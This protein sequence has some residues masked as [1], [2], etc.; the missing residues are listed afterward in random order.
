MMLGELRVLHLVPKANRRRLTSEQLG[1]RSLKAHPHSDTRFPT[2]PHLLI[3]SLLGPSVFKPPHQGVGGGGTGLSKKKSEQASGASTV[4]LL[5][6]GL[7]RCE[8]S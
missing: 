6:P 7:S 1:G 3:M 8:E 5:L 4:P 2:R